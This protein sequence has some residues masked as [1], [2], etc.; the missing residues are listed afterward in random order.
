MV[1]EATQRDVRELQKPRSGDLIHDARY[2]GEAAA[3]ASNSKERGRYARAAIALGVAAIE[4]FSNDAL[5]SIYELLIDLWPSECVGYEPWRSFASRSHRPI[6][7]LLTRGSL[8]KKVKYLIGHLR[9]ISLEDL[10]DLERN[11]GIVIQARSRVLHMAYLLQPRKASP[12]LEARQAVHLAKLT[13][14]TAQEYIG[15]LADVFEEIH[16]PIRTIRRWED[17]PF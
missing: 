12:V 14:E 15:L 4:A 2:F 8:P 13:I 16:L 11:I 3:I 1:G 17:E 10:T 7:Y 9:R 5:V 6:V